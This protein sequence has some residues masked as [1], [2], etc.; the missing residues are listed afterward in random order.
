MPSFSVFRWREG[1]GW[2]ILAGGSQEGTRAQVLSRASADGAVVVLALPGGEAEWV[3]EDLEDMG[4]PAGYLVDTVMESDDELRFRIG[5]AGV[6]VLSAVGDPVAVRSAVAGAALDGIAQAFA[7][8][9]IVLAEGAA[10]QAF[11]AWLL[12]EG[13][14]PDG[15][16][17]LDNLVID[18][19]PPPVGGEAVAV[20]EMYPEGV[21]LALADDAAVAFGPDGQVELWGSRRVAVTLGAAYGRDE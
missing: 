17:W 15:F 5:E 21:A 7:N 2:L 1:R 19:G 9:G 18:I 14:V 3:L 10:A 16:G 11:G 20:L 12:S 8:G 13:A 6:V 4:A